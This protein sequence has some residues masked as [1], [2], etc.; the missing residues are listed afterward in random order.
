MTGTVAELFRDACRKIE[1]KTHLLDQQWPTLELVRLSAR[2]EDQFYWYCFVRDF[3]W[4]W[5]REFFYRR[6]KKKRP[7]DFPPL[8]QWEHLRL[9]SLGE[10]VPGNL[11]SQ[12]ELLGY[13]YDISS[14]FPPEMGT[15]PTPLAIEW[16]PL[17]EALKG[18]VEAFQR[19]AKRPVWFCD[20]ENL[21]TD[22]LSCYDLL[23][24][25]GQLWQY[26]SQ[27]KKS[28]LRS[29]HIF[30]WAEQTY[31]LG[32]N[33]YELL[34]RE[35]LLSVSLD[36]QTLYA[37]FQGWLE[38]MRRFRLGILVDMYGPVFL[39]RSLRIGLEGEEIAIRD[40]SPLPATWFSRLMDRL[41]PP[42][43]LPRIA[44]VKHGNKI[45]E[46]PRK[47]LEEVVE[48]VVSRPSPDELNWDSVV[49]EA[50]EFLKA[51]QLLKDF[52]AMMVSDLSPRY[53]AAG[54][55]IESRHRF[56]QFDVPPLMR[57]LDR[58]RFILKGKIKGLSPLELAE[59]DELVI[60][61]THWLYDRVHDLLERYVFSQAGVRGEIGRHFIEELEGLFTTL[62]EEYN[63]I[64]KYGTLT[65]FRFNVR[66][67]FSSVSLQ[68]KYLSHIQ[69][70]EQ[71]LSRLKEL[72][73][74]EEVRL[75]KGGGLGA[76]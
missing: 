7:Q 64:R 25:L 60:K 3:R 30:W 46:P 24:Y 18:M 27:N 44:T 36:N 50:R 47:R 42:V 55:L 62:S 32:V 34:K 54:E 63:E 9:E 65:Q 61:S 12:T 16:A 31:L 41:F 57:R 21:S 51:R 53:N 8:I 28:F 72:L 48:E 56:D 22:F 17:K 43:V 15:S 33:L 11:L 14:R 59:K 39:D 73:A 76:S 68:T 40:I 6:A 45:P 49:F 52:V 1:W 35:G 19:T 69:Q 71:S 10:L 5:G 70:I 74:K 37:V 75:V 2:I 26:A 29:G 67:I 13:I 66:R 58:E 38:K 20:L 4:P 23:V